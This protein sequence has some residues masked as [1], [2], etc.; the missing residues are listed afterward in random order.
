MLFD[1]LEPSPCNKLL[2]CIALCI[3]YS[4]TSHRCTVFYQDNENTGPLLHEPT[5]HIARSSL[6][7]T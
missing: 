2:F 7:L 1:L 3:V 6:H 5:P 4:L